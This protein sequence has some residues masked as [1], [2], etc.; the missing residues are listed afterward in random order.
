MIEEA[1]RLSSVAESLQRWLASTDVLV[2][3][4]LQEA[5]PDIRPTLMSAIAVIARASR[6]LLAVALGATFD[7]FSDESNQPEPDDEHA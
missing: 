1:S 3:H 6:D 4:G 7:A 2:G 5:G